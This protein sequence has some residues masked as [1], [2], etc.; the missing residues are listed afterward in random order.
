[1][2]SP[3]QG[4][5]QSCI[6]FDLENINEGHLVYHSYPNITNVFTRIR[7][8]GGFMI[9]LCYLYLLTNTGKVLTGPHHFTKRG[10]LGP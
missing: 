2:P 4:S 10:D 8:A 1:V 3:G 9:Y 6:N 7:Y 5:E